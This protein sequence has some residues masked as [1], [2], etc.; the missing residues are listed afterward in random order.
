MIVEMQLLTPAGG[1]AKAREMAVLRS[2]FK[3]KASGRL[4]SRT[5]RGNSRGGSWYWPLSIGAGPF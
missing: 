3:S 1:G 2:R 5:S 4:P